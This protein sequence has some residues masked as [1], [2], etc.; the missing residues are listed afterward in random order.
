[1]HVYCNILK[2]EEYYVLIHGFIIKRKILSF[3]K[4]KNPLKHFKKCLKNVFAE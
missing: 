3:H 2:Y 1:M 4:I